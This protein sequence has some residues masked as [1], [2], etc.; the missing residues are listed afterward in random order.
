MCAHACTSTHTCANACVFTHQ[1]ATTPPLPKSRKVASSFTLI[2]HP[3]PH[4]KRGGTQRA[5]ASR[6]M[7][8][9]P[10]WCR[11][12]TELGCKGRT[13]PQQG[14]SLGVGIMLPDP[15]FSIYMLQKCLAGVK[16]SR[17]KKH[18]SGTP[19][20]PQGGERGSRGP[21]RGHERCPGILPPPSPGTNPLTHHGQSLPSPAKWVSSITPPGTG[22]FLMLNSIS[23]HNDSLA[24]VPGCPPLPK[25]ALIYGWEAHGSGG[26][27]AGDASMGVIS[28]MV[29]PSFS[30]TQTASPRGTPWGISHILPL[31]TREGPPI[32]S[33][34]S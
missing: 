12:G 9:P 5:Q 11:D 28:S 31:R 34:G 3:T 23:S 26:V 14:C 24:G 16:T 18:P 20:V 32:P 6:K 7:R 2:N 27:N 17:G 25:G 19:N 4:G 22:A 10:S 29:P 15:R 30:T 13:A 8:H 1:L 21:Q 33:P